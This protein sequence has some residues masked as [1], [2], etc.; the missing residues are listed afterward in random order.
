[1]RRNENLR[2]LSRDHHYSLLFGWKIRQGIRNHAGTTVMRQYVSWFADRSLFPH[3]E[4]EEREVLVFLPDGD[5]AKQQ[6]L[7]DHRAIREKVA[8]V[9][10]STRPEAVQ[11]EELAGLATRLDEHIRLEERR[12]FPYLERTLTDEQ[13]EQIGEAI[14]SGHTPFTDTFEHEFWEKNTADQ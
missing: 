10:S 8:E 1:M 4:H 14:R 7:E 6:I 5:A 13:L 12:L 3:F 11:L 9:V 2:E